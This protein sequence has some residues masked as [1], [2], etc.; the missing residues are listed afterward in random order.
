MA[1][2]LITPSELKP[3]EQTIVVSFR[4]AKAGD[5]RIRQVAPVAPN[6]RDDPRVFAPQ[7]PSIDVIMS[8][9]HATL[10]IQ[11]VGSALPQALQVTR[12]GATVFSR[13][14]V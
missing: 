6:S 14:K 12:S 2:G 9:Q 13:C 11:A 7:A 4:Q 5:E 10:S 8:G 3:E 1:T